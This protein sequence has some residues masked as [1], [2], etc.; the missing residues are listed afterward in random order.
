MSKTLTPELMCTTTGV[1]QLCPREMLPVG[2]QSFHTNNLDPLAPR[3]GSFDAL[4]Q[5]A[6]SDDLETRIVQ[7]YLG[8][9]GSNRA[10]VALRPLHCDILLVALEGFLARE[11]LMVDGSLYPPSLQIRR[12]HIAPIR[13]GLVEISPGRY[14]PTVDRALLFL[15][16][17]DGSRLVLLIDKEELGLTIMTVHSNA[18]AFYERWQAFAYETA[19]LRGQ[20]FYA[21]GKLI[22]TDPALRFSHVR[23]PESTRQIIKRMVIEFPASLAALR[24]IGLPAKRGVLFVGPPGMGKTMLCRA[25][26]QEIQATFIWVSARHLRH[27]VGLFAD[28]WD[29]GRRLQ[30]TIMLL[31]D[32]DLFAESRATSGETHQLAELMNQLDGMEASD[33]ILTLATTNRLEHVEDALRNRPGRFDRIIHIDKI[34]SEDRQALVI[35]YLTTE[36]VDCSAMDELVSA[37]RD[38]TGAQ[39]VEV[40][41]SLVERASQSSRDEAGRMVIDKS[42]VRSVVEE[43]QDQMLRPQFGFT[44]S[45]DSQRLGFS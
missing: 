26:C 39:V 12:E 4:V 45:G 37:T 31:E 38:M 35:R 11:D 9:P 2:P 28:V 1:A 42:L 40:L 24:T 7:G 36:H 29:L 43:L 44:A 19:Y 23:L 30:P 27:N 34:S 21:D 33:G 5:T 17:R 25:L 20:R 18:S 6:A 15:R 8:C 10:T 14:R 32:I 41:K 16:H 13:M 3:S 22:A